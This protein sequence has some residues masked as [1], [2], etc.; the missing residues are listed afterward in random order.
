VK[1]SN[2]VSTKCHIFIA[3]HIYINYYKNMTL[4]IY[5]YVCGVRFIKDK[6]KLI[7]FGTIIYLIR[8]VY[9]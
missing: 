9:K 8:F 7:F 5:M 2:E 4:Y 3:I 1:L 6:I